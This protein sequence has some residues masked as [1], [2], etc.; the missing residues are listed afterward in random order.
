MAYGTCMGEERNI[1]CLMARPEGSSP[2]EDLAIEVEN[3]IKV[4]LE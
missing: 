1:W 4:G 2:L 3:D